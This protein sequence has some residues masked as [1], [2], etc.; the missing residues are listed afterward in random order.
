MDRMID[1]DV[2]VPIETYNKVH[3]LIGEL[4][5]VGKALDV[6]STLTVSQYNAD[7]LVEQYE[8]DICSLEHILYHIRL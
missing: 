8:I 1:V 7:E 6:A 4:E 3:K 5:G 2:N